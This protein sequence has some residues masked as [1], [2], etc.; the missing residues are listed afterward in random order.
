MKR[1]WGLRGSKLSLA[2][3]MEACFGVVIFGYNQGSAGGV[4]SNDAFNAR[5]PQ[6]DTVHTEGAQKSQNARIQ[7]G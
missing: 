1:F 2:I 3:W 4:L 5:F 7:G 6:I